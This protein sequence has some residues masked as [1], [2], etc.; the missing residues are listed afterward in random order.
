MKAYFPIHPGEIL[1][2]EFLKPMN[3]D[4][5]P[6]SEMDLHRPDNIPD[7]AD[8]CLKAISDANLGDRFVEE[9]VHVLPD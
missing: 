2:E 5:H 3:I 1:A 7:Y 4:H 9:F 6:R 8:V